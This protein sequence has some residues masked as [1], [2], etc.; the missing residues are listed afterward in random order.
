MFHPAKL[1]EKLIL[2]SLGWKNYNI[3]TIYPKTVWLEDCP[4]ILS[5]IDQS[6]WSMHML[7]VN[8]M[9]SIT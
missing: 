9:K 2:I 1:R 4:L 3:Y 6:H 8:F 5:N 7:K